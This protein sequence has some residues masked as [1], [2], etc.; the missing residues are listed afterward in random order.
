MIDRISIQVG[1]SSLLGKQAKLLTAVPTSWDK[2]SKQEQIEN[3]E[4]GAT[5]VSRDGTSL[6]YA[7]LNILEFI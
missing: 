7:A 6:M 2:S 4:T 3:A 1:A 5:C